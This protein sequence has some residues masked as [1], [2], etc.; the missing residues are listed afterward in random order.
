MGKW[1]QNPADPTEQ[2]TQQGDC[3]WFQTVFQAFSTVILK[4]W[5]NLVNF[6][7]FG[8]GANGFLHPWWPAVYHY[9]QK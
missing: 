9:V 5:T 4:V 1:E 3:I 7:Y 2:D 6:R 8:L